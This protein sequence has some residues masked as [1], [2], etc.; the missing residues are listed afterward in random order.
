MRGPIEASTVSARLEGEAW[1]AAEFA[2]CYE[3]P[4]GR[5]GLREALEAQ[6]ALTEIL[7]QLFGQ[8][9]E[10]IPVFA[11]SSRLGERVEDYAAAWGA[12]VVRA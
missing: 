5:D 7:R 2:F 4:A 8:S 10:S 12:T 9:A 11:V 3:L 1:D 6:R